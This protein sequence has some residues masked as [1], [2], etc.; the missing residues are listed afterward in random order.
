MTNKKIGY[1][2]LEEGKVHN[3]ISKAYIHK[4]IYE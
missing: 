2:I 3:R 4:M 1:G